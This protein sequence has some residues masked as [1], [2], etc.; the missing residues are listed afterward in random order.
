ME[1]FVKTKLFSLFAE[2]AA[3]EKVSAKQ[4]EQSYNAFAAKVFEAGAKKK[5]VV[6]Y[7]SL[8]FARTE[9]A[10]WQS[11]D[12]FKKT[13]SRWHILKKRRIS[14]IRRLLFASGN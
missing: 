12:G 10:C 13:G 8:C 4:W 7:N 9:L 11:P 2:S 5:R 1:Q 3:G 6:L 14:L